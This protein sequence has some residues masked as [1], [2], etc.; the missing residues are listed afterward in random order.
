MRIITTVI[1][2]LLFVVQPLKA[3]KRE[4]R[5]FYYQHREHAASFKI[6][7]G[8]VWLKMASWIVPASVEAEDGMPL[9]RLLSKVHHLKIYTLEGDDDQPVETADIQN[10]KDKL[11]NKRKFESLMEVRHEHSIVHLLNKGKNDEIGELVMLVQDEKD[12]VIIHLHTNLHMS[13]INFLVQ[14]FAKG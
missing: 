11:V 7:I 5:K 1:V 4:L 2:A 3:Q 14:A 9:K 13:D 10:L 8:G 6:G 12:F